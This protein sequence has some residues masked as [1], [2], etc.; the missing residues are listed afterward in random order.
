MSELLE[1][2]LSS[3]DAF[4]LTL[5][6]D[7][8]LRAT[9]V[10]LATFDRRPDWRTLNDRIERATRLIPR[11]REKLV[12]VPFGLAPPRWVLD[13]DFDLALH[14]RRVRVHRGGGMAAVL[15]M[16]RAAGLTSF[17]YERPLWEFT[18]VEG[19]PQNRAA[20]IM[21]IHHALTD[22]VGGIEI[23]AHVVDLERAGTTMG[24]MPAAP[25]GAQHGMV[26]V[27]TDT[28]DYHLHRI[29]EA[30][31][32]LRRA[33]PRTI[34]HTLR[35]PVGALGDGLET[36]VAVAKFVRPV[37]R[38]RSPIMSERRP[39]R[40]YTSLDVPLGD[41][42]AAAHR[43]DATLNDAFL[44]GIAGGMR[45]YHEHHRAAVD[46]LRVTM[47]VNIRTAQ[48]DAGG[49]RVTLER[50]DL[51][52]GVTDPL[53]RMTE[54]SRTCRALRHDPAI[55]YAGAIAG[56]LNLLPVDV[57]AGMLKHVDLLASNVPGFGQEVYLGGALLE[58][59]HVFGATLG[60]AVNVTLMSYNGTCHIGVNTDAGA[61]QDPV[62]FRDSLRDGFAEVTNS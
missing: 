39:L 47:P 30:G 17:D 32:G 7:P 51:P 41:L 56:A 62:T 23:A 27:V 1:D 6:R 44:A 21:K 33:L 49:N 61:V 50:F 58:S 36:A 13:Q 53:S 18:L 22:G 31:T 46:R 48:D 35:D 2:H 9:F 45:R 60:S 14:L 8:L 25:T 29:A 57:T 10:A 19:L 24:P 26:D 11:F 37:T 42:A 40:D 16:A 52:V 4:T 38:T 34:G 59:F 43:V 20:L 15:D 28:I 55:P 12:P 3:V 5:E 54:I